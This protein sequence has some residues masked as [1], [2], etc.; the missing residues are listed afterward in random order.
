M[1]PMHVNLAADPPHVAWSDGT[2]TT[3]GY[4]ECRRVMLALMSGE[5]VEPPAAPQHGQFPLADTCECNAC[6]RAHV[7]MKP[8]RPPEQKRTSGV[9]VDVVHTITLEE[10]RRREAPREV[11][12]VL[13]HRLER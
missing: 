3:P 5:Y 11:H 4:D 8:W 1:I 13:S 9:H 7:T 12:H 10:Y 2:L 6:L